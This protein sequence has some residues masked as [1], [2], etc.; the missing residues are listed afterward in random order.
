[1]V[2]VKV[3]AQ[4]AY[5]PAVTVA[6]AC[7]LATL[8]GFSFKIITKSMGHALY[9]DDDAY[10][11]I[12]TARNISKAGLS[13]FDGQSLTNGYHPLWMLILVLQ[14]LTLGSSI[15]V[16]LLIES[17]LLSAGLLLFIGQLPSRHGAIGLGFAPIFVVLFGGIGLDGMEVALLVFSVSLFVGSLSHAIRG[18][19]RA[20]L[21]LG[22]AAAVTVGAR[23]DSAFFVVPAL[24][25]A[26]VSRRDRAWAFAVLTALGAV[27]V[28]YNLMTFG[29]AMPVSSTI[30]S[31]GGLQINHRLLAQLDHPFDPRHHVKG[32]VITLAALILSPA[33]LALVRRGSLSWVLAIASSVGGLIYITKLL[34]L[35]SWKIWPWYNFAVLFPLLSVFY[36][37]AARADGGGGWIEAPWRTSSG[38]WMAIAKFASAGVCLAVLAM[39]AFHLP[40]AGDNGFATINRLAARKFAGQLNGARVAMGDRAGS[41]AAAYDGPVVQLEG[42]VNDKPYLELIRRSGDARG[43]LCQRGVK[44]LASY[45]PDLGD[46]REVA[47][48][49]L[50]PDLTQFPSP[51]L[52]VLRSDEI[53]HFG[54]LNIYESRR[55]DGVG[56][57][58]LYF[59]RLKC[60]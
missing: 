38:P 50:R 26:P 7:A 34:L 21:W 55:D 47:V 3:K 4:P 30:K 1:M 22:L 39:L 31:L 53:G 40:L 58:I 8:V 28:G 33:L 14:N 43:L 44:A 29:V 15:F 35:S 51:T 23:I 6:L 52:F 36:A 59:W 46:Y 42:L 9:V 49:L 17:A 13:S 20:W 12:L 57:D 10:Y 60:P 56:D 25:A 11:Y 48:P 5:K 19:R 18:G 32:Y 54:D 24:V 27:Y 45:E 2:R 37:V 41:F 16:T